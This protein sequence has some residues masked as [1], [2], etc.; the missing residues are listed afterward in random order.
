[1]TF[2][3]CHLFRPGFSALCSET[4]FVYLYPVKPVNSATRLTVAP[5]EHR[6]IQV[7]LKFEYFV[8]IRISYSIGSGYLTSPPTRETHD[9]HDTHE[10]VGLEAAVDVVNGPSV[11]FYLTFFFCYLLSILTILTNK[12]TES[13]KCSSTNKERRN[14][15][16]WQAKKTKALNLFILETR[17]L[18]KKRSL[19]QDHYS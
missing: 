17:P 7:C 14:I 3:Q 6:F 18:I 4:H 11:H 10:V 5:P 12:P 9:V 2:L 16:F 8:Q 13:K 1:M 19:I 15:F